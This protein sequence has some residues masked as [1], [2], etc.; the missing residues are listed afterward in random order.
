LALPSTLESLGSTR[1]VYL[2]TE[3]GQLAF[4]QRS[5]DI[6]QKQ[7]SAFLQFDGQRS[8][9]SVLEAVQAIGITPADIADLI[10]K[11]FLTPAT[12]S[13]PATAAVPAPTQA[14]PVVLDGE[15]KQRRYQAAYPLAVS[16]CA[17]LG[18][19]GFTLTLA[20]EGASGY[21]DLLAL[22]PKMDAALPP[23]STRE[24]KQTLGLV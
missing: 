9:A 18:L 10:A 22:L 13:S 8:L 1:M 3:A 23:G 16:L 17:K 14:P 15:D 2:K 4:K 7:R 6:S 20:V 5:P 19:R 24:L 12:P 21:D 11:G